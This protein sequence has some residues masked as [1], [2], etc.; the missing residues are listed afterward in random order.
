MSHDCRYPLVGEEGVGVV[1]WVAGQGRF[2]SF[3]L[4]YLECRFGGWNFNR[5]C[6]GMNCLEEA[7]EFWDK[8]VLNFLDDHRTPWPSSTCLMRDNSELLP[9]PSKGRIDSGHHHTCLTLSLAG[10]SLWSIWINTCRTCLG[11]SVW[12]VK[13]ALIAGLDVT[14]DSGRNDQGWQAHLGVWRGKLPG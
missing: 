3:P 10:I 14:V 5:H 13:W 8:I 1:D 9:R 12:D 4:C 2:L 11:F 7:T 6:G